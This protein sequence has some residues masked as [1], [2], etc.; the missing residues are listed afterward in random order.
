MKEYVETLREIV[1]ECVSTHNCKTCPFARDGRGV[2]C[3]IG[4]PLTWQLAEDMEAEGYW[5]WD[6]EGG[7]DE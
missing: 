7:E 5:D 6:P 4:Y 2:Y 3:T 1:D